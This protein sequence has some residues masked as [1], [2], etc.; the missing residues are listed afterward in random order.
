MVTEKSYK[1]AN[2][3]IALAEVEKLQ[4]RTL[5][6]AELRAHNKCYEFKA[7]AEEQLRAFQDAAN[8]RSN[9]TRECLNALA[10]KYEIAADDFTFNFDWLAFEE[11]DKPANAGKP[12]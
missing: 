1:M 10:K 12:E 8:A 5:E 9:E 11:K 4:V 7:K 3:L 2:R 6:A